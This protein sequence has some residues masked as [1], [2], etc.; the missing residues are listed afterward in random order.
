MTDDRYNVTMRKIFFAF[1]IVLT[2]NLQTVHAAEKSYKNDYRVEYFLSENGDQLQSKVKFTVTI[3]NLS[4]T[5][6]V[7]KVGI[8]FPDSFKI[9]DVAA[10]DMK[11]K[12]T[13]QVVT[14]DGKINITA[15]FNDP[16]IGQN[17]VNAF[18]LEFN[19][20]NLFRVFGN[21]WEVM[22][23]TIANTSS[24]QVIVHLPEDTNKKISIAKPKPDSIEGNK[25]I[26]RN[27]E[28]KIIYA[29]F[30]DVQY[31][32]LNLEYHL[33]NPKL[34]PVYEDI[35]FPPDTMFQKIY[36]DSI[37]P[38]PDVAMLDEDGNWMG[39]Y[40][41]KPKQKL[42][43][44]FKGSAELHVQPREETVDVIRSEVHNQKSYLTSST[45]YWNIANDKEKGFSSAADIYS[46]V[47][48]TFTYDYKKLQG[49]VKRLGANEALANPELAVCTEFTDTFI[50]LAR[51]KGIYAR[52]IEGYGFTQDQRLRPLSLASDVLHAW[53]E[54]Y[55]TKTDLW[56][57]LDPTWENTS[58]I[59][60]F[61]SFDLNHI[62][63]A[64]HGKKDEYPYPAGS[65]KLENSKDI[66]VEATTEKS[67]DLILVAVDDPSFTSPITDKQTGTFKFT[68]EN[69][70]NIYIWNTPI[71][72]KSDR[73]QVSSDT[74]M[75]HSLPPYGKKEFSFTYKSGQ[76]D[77]KYNA[78]IKLSV[79]GDTLYTGSV[80][81]VPYYYKIAYIV[82]IATLVVTSIYFLLKHFKRRLFK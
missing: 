72:V 49:D 54:F 41:L 6:Y 43:I 35:A 69:K 40:Y 37:N 42:D 46:F 8:S 64:I 67:K 62:V 27:P 31:Y 47:A 58:G 21:V 44:T 55:D 34:V 60:Y 51:K 18:A 13:P 20:D 61:S 81:I 74:I 56:R 68:V 80:T 28:S 78:N 16:E 38:K 71:V 10:A 77:R 2:L 7:D 45:K 22:L 39:R 23:P 36:A 52:E 5:E 3:T 70:G 12:I 19:Q 79:F 66:S 33:E 15:A 17:S 63:F 30:G 75:I 59:D 11:G 48:R 25:I 14:K 24:Y 26:W 32:S 76:L 50:S 1:F 53:P 73:L 65:Y 9:H 29:M 82:S 4:Q 57:P